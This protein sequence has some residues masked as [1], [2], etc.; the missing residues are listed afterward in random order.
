MT[1][2]DFT[3]QHRSDR[4]Y[5]LLYVIAAWAA[6]FIGFYPSVMQR[7]LGQADY[8]APLILEL[9]VFTFCGW[10]SLLTIQ[11]LL[12]RTGRLSVH[13]ILGMAGVLMIPILILTGIGAE[14]FSQAFYVSRDPEN[15]R[16]FALPVATMVLFT[17]FACLAIAWRSDAPTHKRLMLLATTILLVAPYNRWWG[18]TLFESLGDGFVAVIVRFF[19]GPN[20]LMLIA[21]G[22]DLATRGRVHRVLLLAISFALVT[23]LVASAIYHSEWWPPMVRSLL[24][25]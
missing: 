21:M 23:E 15:L 9:H 17:L 22:Y 20:L 2:P 11:V 6:V 1:D 18:D 4:A 25:I 7:Y 8:S 16:F 5:H 24:G 13:R 10:L 19:G 14:I 12:V 3:A